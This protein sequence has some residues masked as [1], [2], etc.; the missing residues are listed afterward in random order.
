MN[1]ANQII[2][3]LKQRFRVETDTDLAARLLISRSSV[4]N[5][6]NRDSVPDRYRKIA[7]GEV[8]WGMWSQPY[9]EM[10]DVER[11]AMR[12]AI[13]RL[14]RDFKVVA[15]DYRGFLEQSMAAAMSWQMYWSTA[16]T[17]LYNEM[18]VRES[19]DAHH[20]ADL[21]VYNQYFSAE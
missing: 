12:I 11:A 16:C 6:R 7:E 14:M 19:E 4:A 9:G 17:D 18:T 21:L 3:K 5:W 15:E 1:D 10:T 8:N 2:E 13:M 20:C